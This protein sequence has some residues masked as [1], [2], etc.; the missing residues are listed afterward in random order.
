[1]SAGRRAVRRPMPWL[2]PAVFTGALVPLAILA[3]RLARGTLGANPIAE[4][5]NQLGLLALVCL[6]ASLTCTPLKILTGKPWHIRL[7]KML[8]LF[9]FLYAC[10]HFSTYVAVE[11]GFAF[12]AIAR[13]I[14]ERPFLLVGFVTLLLLVPLAATSTARM[15]KRLGAERWKRLHRLVYV[16]AVLAIVHFVM[17]VKKDVTEPLVYGAVLAGLLAVRVLAHF[18]Q[19]PVWARTPTD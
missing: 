6:L 2:S 13:D 3:L 5:I 16:C 19:T 11:Q 15:R 10:L 8:G 14:L 9:A 17:R 7:R 12:R 4:A 18:R 1:M